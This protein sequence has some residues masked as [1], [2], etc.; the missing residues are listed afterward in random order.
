MIIIINNII[1]NNININNINIII[2]IINITSSE[3]SSLQLSSTYEDDRANGRVCAC[4]EKCSEITLI[5]VG[6][7]LLFLLSFLSLSP[8]LSFLS[9][10]SLHLDVHQ[11]SHVMAHAMNHCSRCG[12]TRCFRLKDSQKMKDINSRCQ[13]SWIFLKAY[14]LREI[15]VVGFQSF[16]ANATCCGAPTGESMER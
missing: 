5:N 12:D 13:E 16:L 7:H 1:I 15:V 8:L 11:S 3:P 6:I 14:T 10:F 2:I 4:S 9:F